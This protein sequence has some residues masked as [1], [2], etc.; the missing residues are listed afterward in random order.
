MLIR[1]IHACKDVSPKHVLYSQHAWHRQ[2]ASQCKTGAP[3]S[4]SI[5]TADTTCTR[6]R[7]ASRSCHPLHGTCCAA[8]PPLVP[9]LLR[10]GVAVSE[11]FALSDAAGR[12]P[13]HQE[14]TRGRSPAHHEGDPG[15]PHPDVGVSP[16]AR[17]G[18]QHTGP[19]SPLKVNL[20]FP[21]V[22]AKLH[23]LICLPEES[24]CQAVRYSISILH[25]LAIDV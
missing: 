16:T 20:P 2:W 10:G 17:S 6:S 7:D 3:H 13:A 25:G 8:D 18:Y 22:T 4:S 21:T 12:T 23:G 15:L 1:S 14:A 19:S 24:A 5:V 11:S 9:R